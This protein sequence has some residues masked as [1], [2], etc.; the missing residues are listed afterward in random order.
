MR[1]FIRRI[2]YLR[3]IVAEPRRE[4]LALPPQV[5]LHIAVGPAPDRSSRV[6]AHAVVA[7]GYK[8]D[9]AQ[10]GTM[11]AHQLSR[12]VVVDAQDDN[13]P[14]PDQPADVVRTDVLFNAFQR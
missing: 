10:L 1:K 11:L 4:I 12:G 3:M 2:S 7:A 9:I 14:G 13:V 6:L 5:H 8:A